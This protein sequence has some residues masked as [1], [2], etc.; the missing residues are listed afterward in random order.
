M[1]NQNPEKRLLEFFQNEKIDYFLKILN[2]NLTWEILTIS[3]NQWLLISGIL[4]RSK[5]S[6]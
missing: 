3:F 2:Y 5:E 4:E 6:D 1:K